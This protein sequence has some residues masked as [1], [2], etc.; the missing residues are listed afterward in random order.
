LVQTTDALAKQAQH[1]DLHLGQTVSDVVNLTF[2]LHLD[3]VNPF[4]ELKEPTQGR[5]LSRLV[6]LI[7]ERVVL[8]G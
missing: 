1:F 4:S 8:A 5:P 2:H 7:G 6:D 3:A